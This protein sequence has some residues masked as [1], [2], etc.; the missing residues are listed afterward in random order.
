MGLR[1]GFH[2]EDLDLLL[3]AGVVHGALDHESVNLCL[4]ERVNALGLDG[5]NGGDHDER[6]WE[7]ECRAF[8]GHLSLLHGLEERRL[9]LRGRPVYFICEDKVCEYRSTPD[10]EFP[11][12]LVEEVVASY[13]R[14]QKVLRELDTLVRY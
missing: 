10:L 12:F 11:G 2:S 14:R 7:R 6:V 3:V 4:G 9:S 1:R 13:V 8:H 5:V